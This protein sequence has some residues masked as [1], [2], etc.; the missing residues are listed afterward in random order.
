MS[1]LSV[2]TIFAL[3][4]REV[5]K[6]PPAVVE[7]RARAAAVAALAA[8]VYPEPEHPATVTE[9]LTVE[10]V[11]AAVSGDAVDYDQPR[12]AREEQERFETRQT[13]LRMAGE[14]VDAALNSAVRSN[15]EEIVRALQPTFAKLVVQLREALQLAAT[16]D[17]AAALTASAGV[18][19]KLAARFVARGDLDAISA[20]RSALARLG[21][22]SERD[23]QGEFVLLKNVD[24]LYPRPSRQLAAPPWKDQD[25][26]EWGLL[27]GG[28][29]WLPTVGEQD[30]RYNDVY[31]EAEREHAARARHARAVAES[32][33]GA[34]PAPD[35]EG[36]APARP[37]RPPQR[38]AATDIGQ[39][40][41]GQPVAA[42]DAAAPIQIIGFDTE[43]DG[44]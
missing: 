12:H 17:P 11:D 21:Y 2:E 44:S 18:R 4:D 38:A 42:D 31:A 24:S 33:V 37:Q 5:F 40:L 28:E 22:R 14:Q 23:E 8:E 43:A 26:L 3:A 7:A 15:G 32:F 29:I 39:R 30:Q 19:S 9:R 13:A 25:I 16:L 36:N 6:L 10:T 27:N 41:F 34:G 35:Y 20:A 1:Q